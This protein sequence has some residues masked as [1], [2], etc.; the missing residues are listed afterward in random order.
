MGGHDVVTV[1]LDLRRDD[2][3][4]VVTGSAMA[5]RG[6][7]EAAVAAVLQALGRR[8]PAREVIVV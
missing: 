5:R 7:P 6:V 2:A 4:L 3:D 8:L 1:V